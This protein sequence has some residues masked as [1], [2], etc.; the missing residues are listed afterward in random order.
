MSTYINRV[1]K[2]RTIDE[3]QSFLNGAVSSGNT[4]NQVQGSPSNHGPGITGLVG[5][6][7][8]FA[9]PGP[10]GTVTFVASSG[11]NPDPNTLLFKDIKTQIEAAIATLK[12]T[13]YD[14]YLTIIEATPAN[15]VTVSSAGTA[16]T[17]LGFDTANNTVG[18][19]YLPLGAQA[20]PATPPYWV[21]V[22]SL[23]GDNMMSVFTVE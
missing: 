14:G 3:V 4:V 20:A 8:I 5:L 15:G 21:W 13:L 16:N 9:G 1:R 11:S 18:K 23:G 12:V 2:F 7:L 19:Y 6:T 22:N 17:L 10:T